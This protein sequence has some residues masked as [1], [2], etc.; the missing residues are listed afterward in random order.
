MKR[1][2]LCILTFGLFLVSGC[3]KSGKDADMGGSKE[4]F[5]SGVSAFQKGDLDKAIADFTEAIRLDPKY[6]QAYYNRG[7]AYWKGD[8]DKAIAD[9]TEAIRLDPKYAKAYCSR[10]ICLQDKGDYDKAIADYTEAIRLDPKY[11]KAYYNRGMAYVAEGRI[12]QGHC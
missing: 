2:L 4:A 10:G 11:A 1:T 3:T 6:A 7:Y 5:E 8:F 12:R 9:F